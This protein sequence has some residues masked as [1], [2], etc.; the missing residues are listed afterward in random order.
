MQ[1]LAIAPS[2]IQEQQIL[3]TQAQFHYLGRVLRL[4]TGDRFIALD[5]QGGAWLATL[6]QNTAELGETVKLDTEL[7][8]SVTL[9]VAMPKGSGFEE[10]VR[11]GTELGVAVFQPVTSDRTLL[12]PSVNKLQRWRRIA[13]EAA[14]QCERAIIPRVCDPVSL[15]QAL[16]TITATETQG[17]IAAARSEGGLSLL[18]TLS[19]EIDAI[20]LAT[21]PEG[22]WTAAEIKDAIASGFQPVSLGKRIL[23]AV[24]APIAGMGA[25]AAYYESDF[26]R[27]LK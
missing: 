15:S 25:I 22:G 24:T 19:P 10:I 8:V 9:I 2:Q 27:K 17:Y 26:S 4:Q 20:A 6:A 16:Q 7:P 1:R 3:L 18:Q 5:G 12:K 21:G 14:E 23:R 11:Q 13:A